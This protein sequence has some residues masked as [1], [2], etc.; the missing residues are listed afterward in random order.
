M[1]TR[2]FKALPHIYDGCCL[3]QQVLYL[4]DASPHFDPLHSLLG[5]ILVRRQRHTSTEQSSSNR[6]SVRFLICLALAVK[7]AQWLLRS[8]VAAPS[9][10]VLAPP[11]MP[12]A[13]SPPSAA[14][15][16]VSPPNDPALC[17]LCR[18]PKSRPCVSTGGF[19]FC[20][21]CLTKAL[22]R[23]P[24]CPVTGAACSPDDIIVIYENAVV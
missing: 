22:T 2:I 9:S 13:P 4:L 5:I 21:S 24:R 1:V 11:R 6:R 20:H 3:L 14:A 18:R 19:V 7:L 16:G 17:P 15:G 10:S 23:T 8:N 12:P